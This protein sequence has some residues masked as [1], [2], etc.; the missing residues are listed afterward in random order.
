MRYKEKPPL[1]TE[2]SPPPPSTLFQ[3]S[4]Q[5]PLAP[6]TLPNMPKHTT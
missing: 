3:T 4:G 1:E 2:K 5:L 6:P